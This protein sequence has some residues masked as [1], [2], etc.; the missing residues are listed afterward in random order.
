MGMGMGM[1]HGQGTNDHHHHHN[2]LQ[3][4]MGGDNEN[5]A[6]E[7]ISESSLSSSIEDS[8]N[9]KE[10]S[11]SDLDD[12]ASSS[13]SSSPRASNGP[14]FELSQLMDQL[15][16]KKGLSK[17][18][19]GKS[20]SFTTLAKVTSLED[21]A[22]KESPYQRRLKACRSYGGC[23]NNFRS[24][25]NSPKT[26]ISKKVSKGSL[27]CLGRKGSFITT[28]RPPLNPVQTSF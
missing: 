2:K 5:D 12:D 1:Y 10:L 27:S 15:P 22:K 19:K 7:D 8:S 21:L 3:N 14:L 13:S 17:H 25:Y 4:M 11:S 9:S 20:Q 24:Y 28:C 16:I 18:Y 26:R 6:Y 23:L